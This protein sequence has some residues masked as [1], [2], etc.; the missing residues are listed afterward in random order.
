VPEGGE[1][2]LGRGELEEWEIFR[3]DMAACKG[4]P[5]A[6]EVGKSFEKQKTPD[7]KR[8]FSFKGRDRICDEKT[9]CERKH[10]YEK[11]SNE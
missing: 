5:D 3:C 8:G 6:A 1:L 10:P 11:I 2:S 9:N 7:E 4:I